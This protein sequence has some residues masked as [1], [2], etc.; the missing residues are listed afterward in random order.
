MKQPSTVLLI[1]AV[2][3]ALAFLAVVFQHHPA[4]ARLLIELA[5]IVTPKKS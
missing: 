1:A 3:A 5:A 2:A 4:G